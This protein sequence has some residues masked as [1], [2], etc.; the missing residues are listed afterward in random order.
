MQQNREKT[1]AIGIGYRPQHYSDLIRVK[2]PIGWL[3][4]HS[5]NYFGDG[6]K[7]Q[8]DLAQLRKDYPLSFHGVGLSLGSADSLQKNHLLKLKNLIDIFSPILISEHLSWS[9][10]GG[11]YL[12]DLLPLPYTEE[13]LNLLVDRI[14]Q[15]QFFL[16]RQI[17]IENISTYL[18]FS[19]STIPECEFLNELAQRSHCGILL[20]LNNLYVNSYNHGW[21]IDTYLTRISKNHI[22]EIHLAGFTENQ[23]DDQV[24]LIDTHSKP[25]AGTVWDIYIKAIK[26]FGILPTLIEWDQEIPELDVLLKE[27]EKADKIL[28]VHA[29][30]YAS[31]FNLNTEELSCFLFRVNVE[32]QSASIPQQELQINIMQVLTGKDAVTALIPEILKNKFSTSQYLQI[33]RNH[34]FASLTL[35]LKNIYPVT[36]RLVGENFFQAMA[37][38]FIAGQLPI[39]GVMQEF[40]E[41]FSEFITKYS[42]ASNL[43]YLPAVASFEWWCHQAY[44]AAD[45]SSINVSDLQAVSPQEY[46]KIKF[47]LHP[48]HR[49][50]EYAFP[51]LDIWLMCQQPELA[52]TIELTTGIYPILIIRPELTVNMAT[53]SPG[54]YALLSG[55]SQ[56]LEFGKICM[57]ALAAEPEFQVELCLKKH[58]L[59]KHIVDFVIEDYNV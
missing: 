25:I 26:H 13:W 6:G 30:K 22:K 27:A 17:L 9:G 59:N 43:V 35:V 44:Y 42:P 19:H 45:S 58:I 49:L 34:H 56:N 8:Y 46:E 20:D 50:C 12:N 47:K 4:V 23:V 41:N 18:Q 5:E 2:P 40:G 14:N 38:D 24:V 31:P 16:N 55:F 33:Y 11:R 1:T 48:S 29:E 7:P 21:D 10:I 51:V 15:V 52:K 57:L 39:S 36:L 37:L 54:E 28:Q 3:E 32:S 53:L